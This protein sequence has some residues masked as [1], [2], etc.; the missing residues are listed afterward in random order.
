MIAIGL[1]LVYVSNFGEMLGCGIEAEA[2]QRDA[3]EFSAPQNAVCNQTVD[4][5]A[6]RRAYRTRCNSTLPVL[7]PEVAWSEVVAQADDCEAI[8]CGNQLFV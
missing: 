5:F 1:Q 4:Y 3:G 8:C 6:G 2:Q 7:L